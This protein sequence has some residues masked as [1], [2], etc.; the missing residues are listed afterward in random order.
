[1]RAFS[2]ITVCVLFSAQALCAGEQT[3]DACMAPDYKHQIVLRQA[4]VDTG[5][6][7]LA[8]RDTSNQKDIYSRPAGGYA[9]FAAAT[10]PANL[11][12]LWSPDSKFVAIFE[13]GTK[14]SGNT[15]IYLISGDTVQEIDVPDVMPRIKPHLAA[16]L[17]ALWVRPEVWLPEHGLVLSVEGTQLDEEHGVFRFILTLRLHANKEGKFVADIASFQQDRSIPFSVR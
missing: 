16:E 3:T 12:C 6:Y 14:R 9:A 7:E 8:I 10:G 5:G 13:R 1:M 17:R 11:R 4:N 2:K 15:T